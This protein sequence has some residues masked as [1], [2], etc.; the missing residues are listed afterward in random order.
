LQWIATTFAEAKNSKQV[1][2]RKGTEG[3]RKKHKNKEEL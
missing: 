3:G 1:E 2:A